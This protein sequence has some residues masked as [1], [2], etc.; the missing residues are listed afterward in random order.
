MITNMISTATTQQPG[1]SA[2][3]AVLPMRWKVPQPMSSESKE[4]KDSSKV[5]W[6]CR[7]WRALG[8]SHVM[9][10][11]LRIQ[12]A[13]VRKL[14]TKAFRSPD[15]W[16]LRR[17]HSLLWAFPPGSWPRVTCPSLSAVENSIKLALKV[18]EYW[19]LLWGLRSALRHRST[20]A[21]HRE[22][23]HLGIFS[24]AS[25]ATWSHSKADDRMA[26]LQYKHYILY[27]I[28]SIWN[29]Y[30]L[31]RS[32]LQET[33]NTA[34]ELPRPK[35]ARLLAGWLTSH[36]R[37][38]TT[39]P[40]KH[41][42]EAGTSETRQFQIS[43]GTILANKDFGGGKRSELESESER[44]GLSGLTNAFHCAKQVGLEFGDLQG[45]QLLSPLTCKSQK[46]LSWA[47]DYRPA[48]TAL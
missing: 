28:Y 45:M 2:H 21:A 27:T 39:M 25:W 31:S 9:R 22:T 15:P 29:Y 38:V 37:L 30:D 5:H 23:A 42:E 17:P 43:T 1:C 19:V 8:S 16:E 11:C 12:V 34:E 20:T 26:P 46:L 4:R 48:N 13:W 33:G 47:W 10:G 36:L 6:R 3:T 7:G 41:T 35:P 24:A 14:G 18:W 32:I 40:I 44:R